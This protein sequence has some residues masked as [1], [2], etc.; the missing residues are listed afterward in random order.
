MQLVVAPSRLA[1]EVEIPGSKSHTIRAVV[2]A[3][4]AS[5]TSRIVAPLD[6]SDT[7]AALDAARLFGAEVSAGEEWIVTGTA[8]RPVLPVDVVDVGNS[9]TTLRIF[10][11]VAALCDGW[12]FFTGDEQTKRRP[13]QPLI[14]AYR[15]LG[16]EGFCARGNGCAPAALRGRITGGRTEIRAVTS[17]F[18][19]SLLVSAP[20]AERDTEIR[21]LQLNEAPYVEMTLAWLEGLGV[22][23]ERRGWERFSVRGGQG[24]RAFER[25]IPGDFSSATFFLCAAAATGSELLVRGLDTADVQGDRAVVGMLAEMGAKVEPVPGGLRI[26]GGDL[27]GAEFD[28]NATPDALPALA[29]A[30]CFASGETRLR[31]VPQARLKETDRIAVMARELA[32]MGADV[33]ELQDG[34]VIRGRP[35]RGARV[36]GHGDHRVVMALAVAGL[37]AEGE[38]VVD[39][40]EA[41]RVT[42]PTFVDLMRRCGASMELAAPGARGEGGR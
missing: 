12:T 28:L 29:A 18:L 1:G 37:A 42:F 30:A 25:R 35:L 26:R 36:S 11:G 40:A 15:L 17:Q 19:S 21:V 27:R 6:S 8:G 41:V 22:V 24:Y 3:S 31:N 10:L 23:W 38:T 14:D 9:G 20:L 2:L 33:E 34:L 13:L 16:A 39:T 5:G 4:L 7:R 32:K